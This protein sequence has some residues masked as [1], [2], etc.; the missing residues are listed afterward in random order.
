[1]LFALIDAADSRPCEPAGVPHRRGP[2]G[3]LRRAAGLTLR[4][5]DAGRRGHRGDAGLCLG[6]GAP[7]R[8]LTV[9][10]WGRPPVRPGAIPRALPPC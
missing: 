4:P 7:G 2:E 9:A 5:G 10:P 6:R 8:R 3:A 1:M